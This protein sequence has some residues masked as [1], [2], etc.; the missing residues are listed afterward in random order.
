MAIFI[1]NSGDYCICLKKIWQGSVAIGLSALAARALGGEAGS[2]LSTVIV[3]A[4]VINELVCPT[5]AK[6]SLSLSGSYS[7]K[8]EDLAP[9]EPL[10]AEGRRKAEVQLLIERIRAIQEKLPEH[11]LSPEE[12]AF[13]AAA[14]EYR[15]NN[16]NHHRRPFGR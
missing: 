10:D 12:E 3:A 1:L 4:S 14:Q 7:D 15:Q 6:L 13:T 16:F 11:P 5:F 8:L 2:A 9:V